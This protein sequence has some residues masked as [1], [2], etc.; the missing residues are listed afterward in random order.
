MMIDLVDLL[1]EKEIRQSAEIQN[2][3]DKLQHVEKEYALLQT[4]YN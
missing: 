2:L 1:K 4:K 3:K